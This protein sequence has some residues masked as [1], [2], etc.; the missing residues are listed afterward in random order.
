VAP[1]EPTEASA[2]VIQF[3]KQSIWKLLGRKEAYDATELNLTIRLAIESK[4]VLMTGVKCTLLTKGVI[5]IPILY[6]E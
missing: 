2:P 5:T 1:P 3:S 6:I 4:Y